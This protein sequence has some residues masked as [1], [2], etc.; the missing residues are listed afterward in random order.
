[1]SLVPLAPFLD[2]A[3]PER[4]RRARNDKSG[5]GGA[6][7]LQNAQLPPFEILHC[8]F[9]FLGGGFSFEGAEVST[10]APLRIFLS[11]IQTVTG[12]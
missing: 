6:P 7:P 12:F 4:S 5:G 1:M 10:F 9:V 2:E 11:R 3:C 8:F